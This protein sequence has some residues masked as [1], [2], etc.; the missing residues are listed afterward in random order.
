M[1]GYVNVKNPGRL[2]NTCGWESSSHLLYPHVDVHVLLHRSSTLM[3]GCV[4]VH[5]QMRVLLHA[6]DINNQAQLF[7]LG[8]DET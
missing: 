1:P 3:L 7:K 5:L 6:H 4:H 2:P 8:Q